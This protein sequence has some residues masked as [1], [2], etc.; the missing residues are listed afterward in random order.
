MQSLCSMQ[1]ITPDLTHQAPW[2]VVHSDIRC[3]AQIYEETAENRNSFT[4]IAFAFVYPVVVPGGA[5]DRGISGNP[6][7]YGDHGPQRVSRSTRAR[8]DRNNNADYLGACKYGDFNGYLPRT[9][10]RSSD[11]HAS[12]S[13]ST[14]WLPSNARARCHPDGWYGAHTNIAR[15]I[16][17][18]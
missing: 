13:L 8:Q 7:Q 15:R 11:E 12:R 2:R 1:Y 17:S 9:R 14:T 6:Y 5:N 4:C 18:S 16:S 10:S 3:Y